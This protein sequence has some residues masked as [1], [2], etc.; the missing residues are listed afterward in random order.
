MPR[1]NEP[2]QVLSGP[3]GR[4]RIHY[5]A[6]PRARLDEE[7]LRFLEWFNGFRDSGAIIHASVAHLWFET[8]HPFE[9]GNGRLGRAG[10]ANCAFLGPPPVAAAPAIAC[11]SAKSGRCCSS[12]M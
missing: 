11:G 9:D 1:G 7:M 5:E 12:R 2:T 10:G 4:E 8:L 6:P 3:I